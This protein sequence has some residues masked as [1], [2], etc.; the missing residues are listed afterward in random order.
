MTYT[1]PCV[2]ADESFTVEPVNRWPT[3]RMEFRR[4]RL[5]RWVWVG[6][7]FAGGQQ[8]RAYGY[9]T[10]DFWNLVEVTY[11]SASV[12]PPQGRYLR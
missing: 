6:V 3:T 8:G 1:P 9:V 12:A 11:I 2:H 7:M 4:S 10:D 5:L